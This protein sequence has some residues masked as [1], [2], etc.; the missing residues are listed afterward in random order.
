MSDQ[1]AIARELVRAG[2]SGETVVLASV[3]RTE[4]TTYR[5]VGSRM[6]VR[7]DG[8]MIGLLS[9]GCLEAELGARAARVRDSG[10]AEI[11]SYDGRSDD[12]L[13][14]G[15]GLGCNGLVEILL[16]R[17][18]ASGARALGEILSRVLDG[19]SKCVIATVVRAAGAGAPDVGARA[20]VQNS[21]AIAR[22]GM[23]GDAGLLEAAIADAS[24]G[25]VRER[26]G[27]TLEYAIS[28]GARGPL[29]DAVT[30]ELSYELV[31]PTVD[32][33]IC[34]SGPDVVPVSRLAVSLGWTVTVVDPRPAALIPAERFPGARVVECGHSELLA[35]VI[36]PTA[37]TAAIVMSH[38]Y[39]RDLDYL[40][41]LARTDVAYIGML[42]PRARTERLLRDLDARG[43]EVPADARSRIHAP[44]GLDLGGDGAD[45]IALSIIA[46]VSAVMH[47]RPGT[48]LR[49]RDA[50]IHESPSLV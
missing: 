4:G 10:E 3:V 15:V 22:D 28:S 2:D 44:I 7:G 18:D 47:A 38:N 40:D 13:I 25:P 5:G 23:W 41:A 32:L 35:T 17:R 34:G 33:I 27:M 11:M 36:A 12:E 49:E 19:D 50:S 30:A 16:E 1:R 29:D 39:E 14:W 37:R 31:A 20:F 26:H 24:S 43:R 8:T 42:G 21:V 46:E 6:V 9:G 48:H 45:A